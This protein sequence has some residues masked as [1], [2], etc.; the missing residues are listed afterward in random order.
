MVSRILS[1]AR[2]GGTLSHWALGRSFRTLSRVQSLSV[3]WGFG[4]G[5]RPSGNGGGYPY[6]YLH[7]N[8]T[9][10]L[11]LTTLKLAFVIPYEASVSY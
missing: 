5:V 9:K 6:T 11:W 4:V 2:L 10:T 8:M 3:I 7:E 1:A